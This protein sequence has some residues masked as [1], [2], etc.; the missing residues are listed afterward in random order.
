MR[1]LKTIVTNISHRRWITA[2]TTKKPQTRVGGPRTPDAM[3][4][5]MLKI[6]KETGW[7][8]IRSE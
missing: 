8:Y 7:D 3:L 2:I 5:L 6:A 1:Q 4:D